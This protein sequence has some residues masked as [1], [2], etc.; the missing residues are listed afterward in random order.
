MRVRRR[1]G[2]VLAESGRSSVCFTASCT[3]CLDATADGSHGTRSSRGPG[4]LAA[5]PGRRSIPASDE[6]TTRTALSA[7]RADTVPGR[8][9]RTRWSVQR[10]GM[11]LRSCCLR[12]RPR[13]RSRSRVSVTVPTLRSDHARLRWAHGETGEFYAPGGSSA[14]GTCLPAG[15]RRG[16]RRGGF[17]PLL[18]LCGGQEAGRLLL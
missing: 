8:G 9:I 5:V 13:P 3:W 14:D 11:G 15:R 16:R 6:G 17:I 4:C 7:S 12:H 18:M 10:G 1:T 2:R